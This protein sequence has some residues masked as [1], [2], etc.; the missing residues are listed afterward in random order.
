MRR[1]G[2][3]VLFLGAFLLMGCNSIEEQRKID[4]AFDDIGIGDSRSSAFERMG[5]PCRDT[6]RNLLGLL[7]VETTTWKEGKKIY[8]IDFL[9]NKT[10]CKTFNQLDERSKSYGFK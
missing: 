5:E 8:R 7:S 6:Y 10:V 1:R 2:I 9:N 3:W 4:A